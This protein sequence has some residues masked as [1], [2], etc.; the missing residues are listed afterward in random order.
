ML[1]ALLPVLI[2]GAIGSDCPVDGGSSSPP[3][4]PATTE[5][6]TS[7]ATDALVPL[8][9]GIHRDLMAEAVPFELGETAELFPGMFVTVDHAEQAEE[10]DPDGLPL[11]RAVASYE[12]HTDDDTMIAFGVVCDGTTSP[13]TTQSVYDPVNLERSLPGRTFADEVEVH[14]HLP[15]VFEPDQT[16]AGPAWLFVSD[17]GSQ[18]HTRWPICGVVVG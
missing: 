10:P 4:A 12:N 2:A 3:S 11:V 8:D 9:E 15:S 6:G 13:F 5:A 17:V 18:A 14:V 7:A 16:C 1:V